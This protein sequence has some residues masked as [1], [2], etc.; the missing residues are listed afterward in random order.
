MPIAAVPQYL[1]QDFSTASP[2]MRFS[3]Y[4][5]LWTS[6]EDQEKEVKDRARQK[7]KEA[8]EIKSML[9]SEGMDATI[10]KLQQHER[11]PLPCRWQKNTHAADKAWSSICEMYPS[12]H[13]TMEALIDRQ[14]TL[15]DTLPEVQSLVLD[16]LASAPFTTG[17]GNAHPL[18]NGF[19][20][21]WPYGL[22][23]LPGSGV[24]GVLRQA[25][26]EL[27]TGQWGDTRGWKKEAITAL[28]GEEDSNRAQRGALIFWDVIPRLP[29]NLQL[30][31]MTPHQ[32]KYYRGEDTPHD[33]GQ[34]NPIYY[35]TV[36]PRSGF[37]FHVTCNTDLLTHTCPDLLDDQAWKTLIRE[38]FAHAFDWLGFGAKGAVG[39]GAMTPNETAAHEREEK[40]KAR[41][42]ARLS[43]EEQ[44]ISNL[45]KTFHYEHDNGTLKG[46]SKT[47]ELRKELLEEAET[48][49]NA[50]LRSKAAEAIEETLKALPW[51][52][53]MK[54]DGAKQRMEKLRQ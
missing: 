17:L 14:A 2:G 13:K 26:R 34:P 30:E 41:E 24:K 7:S 25:A 51:S 38:A 3:H 22:P 8:R 21:L 5:Q 10:A 15:F 9:E 20:F 52:K 19:A 45:L 50:S 37:T 6:R 33:S 18:E 11:N 42:F 31:V 46:G 40:R 29:G 53:R 27:S 16:A 48:W 36:P 39:Y 44:K 43:P 35:L 47:A 4:L 28:F 49:D 12:D 23:Y 1:G 54:K 32:A